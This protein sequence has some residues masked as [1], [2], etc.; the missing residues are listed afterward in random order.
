M[1][2]WLDKGLEMTNCS[3]L[4]DSW[5]CG[6][7]VIQQCSEIPSFSLLHFQHCT[8]LRGDMFRRIWGSEH[9]WSPLCVYIL[10]DMALSAR[11]ALCWSRAALGA[12][13]LPG[14][15]SEPP[16]GRHFVT[17]GDT[18]RREGQRKSLQPTSLWFSTHFTKDKW[19][20]LNSSFRESL[21]NIVRVFYL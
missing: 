19:K 14:W 18:G 17:A 1:L 9:C 2:I 4:F 20:R 6:N 10:C 3:V 8:A 15:R 13:Y 5:W 7:S 21:E 16:L 11:L 12:N